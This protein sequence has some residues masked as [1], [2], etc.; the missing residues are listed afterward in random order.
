[1]FTYQLI[2]HP[3]SF[4]LDETRIARVFELV[5]VVPLCSRH[6]D[7]RKDPEFQEPGFSPHSCV[8]P[9]SSDARIQGYGSLW[10]HIVPQN[11]GNTH[12]GILNIAFL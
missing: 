2:N 6:P 7:D 8:A 10:S 3:E 9:T 11:D 1:M 12:N 4:T 5:S